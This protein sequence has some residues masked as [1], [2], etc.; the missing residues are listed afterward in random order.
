MRAFITALGLAFCLVYPL[1]A[2]PAPAPQPLNQQRVHYEYTEGN[3]DTVIVMLESYLARYPR[4]DKIDSI[5]IARHLAVVYAA[6]PLQVEKGK[7][8]MYELLR[9]SPTAD[10]SEMYVN[11]EIDRIFEKIRREFGNRHP[12]QDPEAGRMASAPPKPLPASSPSKALS[13]SKSGSS[14]AIYWVAG[15][16]ALAAAGTAA[17]FMFNPEDPAPGRVHEII[18]PMNKD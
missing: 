7:H 8:W 2:S 5:F 13:E 16:V 10:L 4:H 6:N 15:G 3:F 11:E 9:L 1:S 12:A 17:Y 18:I 14:H